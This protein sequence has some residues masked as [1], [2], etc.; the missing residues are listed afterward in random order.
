MKFRTCERCRFLPVAELPWPDAH[1]VT[2]RGKSDAKRTWWNLGH[3]SWTYTRREENEGFEFDWGISSD[4]S[5][6]RLSA[7]NECNEQRATA[8]GQRI[9]RMLVSCFEKIL[10][11][12]M[13]YLATE[14]FTISSV[15][16]ANSLSWSTQIW[17]IICPFAAT[18]CWFQ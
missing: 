4:S 10:K 5:G 2:S 1:V 17:T 12:Q 6:I 18:C 16:Q 8:N 3:R 7:E 11:G 15:T 13:L 9:M 14:S